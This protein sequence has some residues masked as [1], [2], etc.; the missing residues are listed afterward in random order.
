MCRL[1]FT[2]PW[3][4]AAFCPNKSAGVNSAC[5]TITLMTTCFDK[6]MPHDTK[7]V[8]LDVRS[9]CQRKK[10]RHGQCDGCEVRPRLLCEL[11]PL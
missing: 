11:P 7:S 9:N 8:I 2:H 10:Q 6:I 3:A 1:L 5:K 4:L